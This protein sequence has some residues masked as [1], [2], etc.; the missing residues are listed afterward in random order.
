MKNPFYPFPV[1]NLIADYM[2]RDGQ[3]QHCAYQTPG[4]DS[5][6]VAAHAV[7]DLL[8]GQGCTPAC[9]GHVVGDYTIDELRDLADTRPEVDKEPEIRCMF[10]DPVA[11]QKPE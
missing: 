3:W 9:I 5:P 7:Y 4:I 11:A 8:A 10:F 1:V 2:N 6:F